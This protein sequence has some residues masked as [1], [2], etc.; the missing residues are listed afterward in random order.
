MR[1]GRGSRHWKRHDCVDEV[2]QGGVA[3]AARVENIVEDKKALGDLTFSILIEAENVST[4]DPRHLRDCLATLEAQDISLEEAEAVLLI[5]SGHLTA[6]T[7]EHLR[8]TYPWLTIHRLDSG[9]G[10]GGMKGQSA[11]LATSDILVLCDSDCRY[12]L[13]K[14]GPIEY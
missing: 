7:R 3:G 13:K 12:E 2:R 6:E 5:E 9:V 8:S 4:A 11:A 14:L 1:S 10:Y